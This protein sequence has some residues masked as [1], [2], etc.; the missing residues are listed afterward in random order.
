M[1]QL[2]G[3]I[4]ARE[5]SVLLFTV[6]GAMLFL[7]Y[8]QFLVQVGG[9]A[10]WQVGILITVFGLLAVLPMV[11]LGRRFPG[12]ALADIS[13]QVAGRF[14]G[15]LL[16]LL[17]AAWLMAV[18]VITLRSFTETFIITVLPDTPP[19]VLI[20]TGALTAV[21]ASYRGPEAIAR[22]AYLLLPLI[23]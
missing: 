6:L 20:L 14:L 3:H 12:L 17:V 7:Q 23:A 2:E 4:G 9:P 16:T 11:A 10:A 13:E 8:P 19:S 22:T 15:P 18:S 21:F 1:Q 5:G